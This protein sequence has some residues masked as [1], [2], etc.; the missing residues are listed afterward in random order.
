M[1]TTNFVNGSPNWLDL[2]TPDLEAA[3][4]FYGGVLGWR[5]EPGGPETGGYGMFRL[6]GRSVAGGMTVTADQGA[7]AWTVYFHSADP[8][9]VTKAAEQAGCTVL[10]QPM[11]VLDQGRMAILADPAGA[12]FGLWQPRRHTGFEHVTQDGGLNWLE[13]Y[14]P[15]VPA[16]KEFYGSVL[17]WGAFDVE[18]PGGS[19]T[20]VH[21]AGTDE[22]GMFG[23]IVPLDGDPAGAG[24]G[25][26]WTP[27]IHVPDVDAA[28]RKAEELGGAV[29]SAPVGVPGVG[30]IA[31]LADPAG[32][33]FAVIKGDPD[34]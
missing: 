29:R 16:A 2:G 1:I 15:D 27:Y 31:T 7:P 6:D 18:F 25:A 17:G 24:A 22:N 26:H 30:R 33:V 32:A 3:A 14:T 21:P 13:L 23:G 11:D 9:A 28:A 4:A 19:Y 8:D 5:F 20:T 10:L 34:Q 12:A